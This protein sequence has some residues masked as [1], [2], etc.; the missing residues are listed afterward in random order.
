MKQLFFMGAIV[1]LASCGTNSDTEIII[2]SQDSTDQVD[3]HPTDSNGVAEFPI[4]GIENVSDLLD[5]LATYE[6][7]AKMTH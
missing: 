4:D 6:P 2:E 1:A 5:S 3:C 7:K